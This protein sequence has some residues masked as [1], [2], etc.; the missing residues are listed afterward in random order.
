MPYIFMNVNPNND[1]YAEDCVTR[2]ISLATGLKYTAVTNLLDIT[3]WLFAC[4]KLCAACYKHLLSGILHYKQKYAKRGQTVDDI[5]T[6]YKENKLIIRIDGHLTASIYGVIYDT[7]D[8]SDE[9]A[10]CFW[11]V[12]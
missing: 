8:C 6:L 1:V 2:A 11:I 9:L 12:E 3:S 7:F 10:D 4:P 5:S